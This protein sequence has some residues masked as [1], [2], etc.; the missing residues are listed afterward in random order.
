MGS[1]SEGV[2]VRGVMENLPALA[3]RAVLRTG[4]RPPKYQDYPLMA[5]VR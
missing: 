1:E 5:A 3:R 2:Y 4:G